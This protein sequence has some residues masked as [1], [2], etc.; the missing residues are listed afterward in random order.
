MTTIQLNL[1]DDLADKVSSLTNDTESYIIELLRTKLMELNLADEYRMAS[2]ENKDLL[3]DYSG[4][5]VEGF[6]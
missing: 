5:D 4:V 1:P 2:E 3:L 6:A